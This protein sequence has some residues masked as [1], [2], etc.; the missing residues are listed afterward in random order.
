MDLRIV[1]TKKAIAEAFFDLRRD[2]PLEKIRVKDICERA[3]IN[4][5]TFYAHYENIY[6]LSVELG[7]NAID[8]LMDSFEE[9]DLLF[10]DSEAFARGFQECIN[11]QQEILVVLFQDRFYELLPAMEERLRKHY[12][13]N[14]DSLEK[15]M[16]MTFVLSGTLRTM[17]KYKDLSCAGDDEFFKALAGILDKFA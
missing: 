15:D 17:G 7:N 5:S 10:T 11:N 3:L 1:K 14:D 12:I 2:R 4:K 16:L 6:A 9:K 8:Y 13:G